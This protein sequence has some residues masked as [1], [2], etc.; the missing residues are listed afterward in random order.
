MLQQ[1]T[2]KRRSSAVS[3]AFR[4]VTTRLENNHSPIANPL[5]EIVVRHAESR[6]DLKQ[7]FSLAYEVYF[8]KGYAFNHAT[9]W[10]T[11][12]YDSHKDTLILMV[13]N[14]NKEIIG[15]MT[16]YYDDGKFL[17]AD[18]IF[19]TEICSL[20]QQGIKCAEVSR[21]VV[22]KDHQHKKEILLGLINY[23]YIHAFRIMGIDEFIIEVNPRHV[24][25][26][27]KLL[28]YVQLGEIK[29][30]PRVNNAPAVLL[31]GTKDKYLNVVENSIYEKRTLYNSFISKSAES[32][33]IRTLTSKR[34][35]TMADQIY[36]GIRNPF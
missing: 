14:G 29:E 26:Y 31:R 16:L 25:F 12:A 36:F 1:S 21:F 17:P 18:H 7:V 13:E 3:Q 6:A 9:K 20:R 28:G 10:E 32:E 15:S 34:P 30:C 33:V 23:V 4:S 8:E 27:R 11:S 35:M 24:D 19:K 2:N 22:R 5:K